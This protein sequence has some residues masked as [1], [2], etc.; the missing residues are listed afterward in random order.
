VYPTGWQSAAGADYT[1]P[2]VAVYAVG[3]TAV[4]GSTAA[5]LIANYLQQVQPPSFDEVEAKRVEDEG[6]DDRDTWTDEEIREDIEAAM[7][8]TDINWG[9]V[10]R[11]DNRNLDIQ[12]DDVDASGM[13]LEPDTTRMEGVDAQVTG[14]KQL[15]GGEAET[16]TAQNSTVDDQ[17]AALNELKRKKREEEAPDPDGSGDGSVVDRIKGFLE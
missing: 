6:G 17:T 8:E 10:E 14:L 11:S 1:V 2:I 5:G 16:A 15:K 3:L 7:S 13:N 12:V 4:V 9:G